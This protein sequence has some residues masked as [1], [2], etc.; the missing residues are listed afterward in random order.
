MALEML[1]LFEVH[2]LGG[3]YVLSLPQNATCLEEEA[4]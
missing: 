2:Y 4:Q 1:I 3:K